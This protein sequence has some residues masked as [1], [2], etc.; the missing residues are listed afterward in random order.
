MINIKFSKSITAKIKEKALAICTAH[1]KGEQTD[2]RK[3]FHGYY[4]IC[5][6]GIRH[7]IIF[8]DNVYH[9]MTHEQYN[10]IQKKKRC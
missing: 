6:I 8:L 10:G 3:S 5:P 2:F 1:N 9:C 4:L 7:R